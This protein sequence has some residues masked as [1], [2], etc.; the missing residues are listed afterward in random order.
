MLIQHYTLMQ[1]ETKT[2]RFRW[3]F[4]F[5]PLILLGVIG[6]ILVL[7]VNLFIEHIS[8]FIHWWDLKIHAGNDDFQ[9]QNLKSKEV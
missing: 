9:K 5:I 2:D 4:L 3:E 6:E 8:K 1:N 7:P